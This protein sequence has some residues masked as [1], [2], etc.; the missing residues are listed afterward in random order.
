M[1]DPWFRLRSGPTDPAL[2]MAIDQ[3][4]LESAP[5]RGLPVLRSYSWDRPAASFGYFQ[6]LDEVSLLTPLRPLVRRSTGGGVVPHDADWTYSVVIPPGHPWYD[7]PATDSYV[8]MH[9]WLNDAFG[10]IGF[11]TRLAPCCDPSGPGQCFVGAEKSDLLLGD[12]KI[13]GA[14]QRR[15]RLGLLIQGSIHPP[16]GADRPAF[17]SAMEQVATLHHAAAWTD[18]PD[19]SS[20]LEEARRIAADVYA[21]EAHT[22]RR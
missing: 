1:S 18:L 20:L 5:T 6:R 15:N 7:L 16:A 3:A 14:A 11:S 10:R 22:A 2:N 19:A 17:E 8:R 21:S 12:R 13:A 9:R 4:L